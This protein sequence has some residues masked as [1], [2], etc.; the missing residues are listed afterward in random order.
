MSARVLVPLVV[1]A[2]LASIGATCGGS[3]E[4]IAVD[5]TLPPTDRDPPPYSPRPVSAAHTGGSVGIVTSGGLEQARAVTI[6]FVTAVRD[7]DRDV[8]EQLV[9]D[10]VGRVRPRLRTP[11]MPRSQVMEQLMHPARQRF[12]VGSD[13]PVERL[14]DTN[15]IE[16][17]PL[18]QND[19]EGPIPEGYSGTDLRVKVPVLEAGRQLLGLTLRWTGDGYLV[20]RPGPEPRV[21]AL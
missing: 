13:T 18:A 15:A 1:A 8:L 9:A 3:P 10:P 20:I 17:L 7:E 4:P 11:W 6:R 16:V 2:S 14:V 21:V 19:D 12:H 5:T